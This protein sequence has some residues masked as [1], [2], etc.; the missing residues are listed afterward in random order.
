MTTKISLSV[1]LLV[2]SGEMIS[3]ELPT[4]V[5]VLSLSL[6]IGV[7][8]IHSHF[9]FKYPWMLL[10]WHSCTTAF[11]LLVFAMHCPLYRDVVIKH[12]F[13]N[14]YNFWVACCIHKLSCW[15]HV[16]WQRTS[17]PVT[18]MRGIIHY[19]FKAFHRHLRN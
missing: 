3:S 16:K 8:Y 18:R 11:Q 14:R 1:E 19:H 15:K 13:C 5:D 9:I 6:Y 2:M 12:F 4:M 10:T 17:T 7:S